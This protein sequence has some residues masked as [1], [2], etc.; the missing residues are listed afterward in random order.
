MTRALLVAAILGTGCGESAALSLD[1]PQHT[2]AFVAAARPAT[3]TARDLAALRWIEGTWRGTGGGEN[4][5]FERYVFA[6]DST[7]RVDSFA[8]SSLAVVSD[9]S[10][11]ALRGGRLANVSTR[12]QW[13]ASRLKDGAVTF[14][15]VNGARNVFVW[16]PESKDVWLADLSWLPPAD[17]TKKP[18]PPRTYR[19][20]RHAAT[21]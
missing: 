5:F 13:V 11:F 14:V 10:F 17:A 9:T 15:P 8:D 7:L 12:A 3:L 2:A 16:R 4:P 6:D 18:T 19:M 1:T 20:V 21:P